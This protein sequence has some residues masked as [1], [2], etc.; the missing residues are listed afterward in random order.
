MLQ[1]I[2]LTLVKKTEIL[3]KIVCGVTDFLKNESFFKSPPFYEWSKK[4]IKNFTNLNSF[5]FNRQKILK[6]FHL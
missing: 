2:D 3:E 6:F 1:Y 5:N 4:N